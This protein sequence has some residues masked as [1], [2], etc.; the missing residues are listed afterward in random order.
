MTQMPYLPIKYYRYESGNWEEIESSVITEKTINLNINGKT[1]FSFL[2]TPTDLEELAIGFLYNEG[3]IKSSDE[4]ASVEVCKSLENIDVWLTHSLI[5]PENWTRTSGC[6]GGLT[7]STEVIPKSLSL[8]GYQL[9][10]E[11]ICTLVGRL[12]D[13]Q[14]LYRISGGVHTSVLCE[15][16]NVLFLAEDIGRH[17]TLDKIAGMCL[18]EKKNITHGIL[19]TTGRISSEML[20]KAVMMNASFVISRTSPSNL[21]IAMAE[22]SG[23]TLIGYSRKS[24]FNVYTH[25][26]RIRQ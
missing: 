19:L 17:N 24:S 4:V 21:S 20:Q 5:K 15:G 22:A 11:E 18:L 3:L 26:E 1:W 6:V 12:L 16:E 13:S 14:N 7:Q 2:C 25:P 8:N 9:S 10:T 23:L